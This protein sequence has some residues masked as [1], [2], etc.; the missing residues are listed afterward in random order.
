MSALGQKQTCAVQ[1]VMSALPPKADMCS[2]L[3]YV[4]FVPKADIPVVTLLAG[5]V[6]PLACRFEKLDLG[7]RQLRTINLNVELYDLAGESERHLIVVVV[8]TGASIRP[9]VKRLVPLKDEW[10]CSLQ[11]LGSNFFAVHLE[12]A[13]ATPRNPAQVVE[14]KRANAEAVVFEVKHQGVLA[15]AKFAPEPSQRARF[16]SNKFQVNTGL[17]FTR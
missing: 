9:N 6:V 10:D 11:F 16:R 2:A 3:G 4:R 8:N 14:G 12:D 1:K 7:R 13:H 5:A 17:P 15:R